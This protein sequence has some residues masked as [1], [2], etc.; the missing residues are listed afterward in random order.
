VTK[1]RTSESTTEQESVRQLGK[2]EVRQGLLI[3]DGTG[4]DL[5]GVR[6]VENEHVRERLSDV[7]APLGR[8]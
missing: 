5:L 7:F 4:P 1:N 6:E 2:C 3:D 8:D